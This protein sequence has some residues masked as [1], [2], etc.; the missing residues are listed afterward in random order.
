MRSLAVVRIGR[1]CGAPGPVEHPGQVEHPVNGEE[2]RNLQLLPTFRDFHGIM[3]G[4]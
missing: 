1:S 2:S 3:F 4:H